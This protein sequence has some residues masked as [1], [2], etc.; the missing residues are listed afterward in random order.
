M[1]PQLKRHFTPKVPG[2]FKKN[3]SGFSADQTLLGRHVARWN[4]LFPAV[5]HAAP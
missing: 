5:D 4:G 3:R 2:G 1:G